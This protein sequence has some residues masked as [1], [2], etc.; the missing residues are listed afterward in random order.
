MG[1]ILVIVESETVR[2][3]RCSASGK[4]LRCQTFR[5]TLAAKRSSDAW[6][7]VSLRPCKLTL[8]EARQSNHVSRRW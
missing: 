5:H 7:V 3:S 2:H 8:S 4:A 6:D 1:P